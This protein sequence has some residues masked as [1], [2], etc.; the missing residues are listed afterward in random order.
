LKEWPVYA[1]WGRLVAASGWIAVTFD[2]R[3]PYTNSSADIR[4]LFRFVRSDGGRL[5]IQKDRVAA[6]ACSGNVPSGLAVV[7]E[8]A[9]PGLRAAVLYYGASDGAKIRTDLPV[10]FVRAGRDNPRLLGA[11]D[12]LLARAADAGAPWTVVRAPDLHHAFDVLDETEESRRIVR[13]TLEFLREFLS[14]PAPPA[15]APSLARRAL[16]HWFV[17]EYAE[18]AAAYGEYVRKHPDDATATMRLGLSQAHTRRTSEAVSNLQKA[19]RLGADSPSDLYDVGCGYALLDEPAT[20][21][22]WLERAVARGFRDGRLLA[23]DG[24]LESLHGQERFEKLVAAL[25]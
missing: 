16:A 24:D 6:W 18:A 25:Q 23:S 13:E 17:G 21:L 9:D 22:D 14:P 11:I 1:S 5:G 19:V 10:L 4:D 2:A 3:G 12:R 15:A 8:E 7:M 20:A